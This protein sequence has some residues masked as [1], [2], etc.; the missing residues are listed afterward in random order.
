ITNEPAAG[1]VSK[2][3]FTSR[4]AAWVILV[5]QTKPAIR[6][7]PVM[8]TVVLLERRLVILF[9]HVVLTCARDASRIFHRGVRT[10]T[11]RP[12]VPEF[13][14]VLYWDLHWYY[15]YHPFSVES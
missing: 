3:P 8:F 5:V 13:G 10:K 14:G 12:I 9:L 1:P 2:L 11:E 7:S 4:D 6:T 15:R